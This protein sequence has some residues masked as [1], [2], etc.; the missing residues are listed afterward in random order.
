MESSITKDKETIIIKNEGLF[1]KEYNLP[2]VSIYP[3]G[4]L[5][6][7]EIVEF[8]DNFIPSAIKT[9]SNDLIFI[10]RRHKEEVKNALVNKDIKIVERV[11]LW[12]LILEEFLDTEFTEKNKECCYKILEENGISRL[13]CDDIRNKVSGMMVSY[14]FES[15]LW[16][17]IYLGLYDLLGAANG[18]LASKK[19]KLGGKE[20]L[21]LYRN[22]VE[23]AL[24]GSVI[25]A[26]KI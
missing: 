20:H 14:N 6:Y 25:K 17:W 13:E 15:C 24:K 19:Y 4:L 7:C 26:E 21:E 9:K 10:D 16:E 1:F 12:S 3:S 2:S 8:I 11:D 22:S 18:I 5:K 23:L